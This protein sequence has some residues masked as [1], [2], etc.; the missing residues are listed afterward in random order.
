MVVV[1]E[2]LENNTVIHENHYFFAPYDKI[3]VQKAHVEMTLEKLQSDDSEDNSLDSYALTFSTDK[4]VWMMHMEWD[5]DMELMDNNFDL[6]PGVD[7]T[8]IIRGK[9]VSTDDIM[10]YAMNELSLKMK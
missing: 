4:F 8:I 1:A 3:N 6:I 10:F 5:T 7:R 2:I 9:D